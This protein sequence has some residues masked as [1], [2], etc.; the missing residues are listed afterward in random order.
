[1][2]KFLILSA[3]VGM[4]GLG[5]GI[6][7]RQSD[8]PATAAEAAADMT[9]TTVAA[10]EASSTT[11]TTERKVAS[12]KAPATKA[13]TITTAKPVATSST[14]APAVTTTSTTAASTTTTGAPR[15]VTPTC[16]VSA[17]PAAPGT[18]SDPLNK[19][20]ED[21]RISSNMPNTRTRLTVQYPSLKQQFWLETDASGAAKKIFQLKGSG[22]TVLSVDFYDVAENHVGGSPAC[23]GSSEA[24]S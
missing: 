7:G 20:W 21:V 15:Q 12:S 3:I 9:T 4:A 18:Y 6:A 22:P 10:P 14:T 17:T 8:T 13:P 11:A 24:T 1:M 16:S 19:P 23:Q 5:V 2:K